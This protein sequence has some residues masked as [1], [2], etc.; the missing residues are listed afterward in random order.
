MKKSL[1]LSLFFAFIFSFTITAQTGSISGKI[2]TSD[3]K[4]AEFV[5]VGIKNTTHGSAA[6]AQGEFLL[7]NVQAGEHILVVSLSGFETKEINVKV[8]EGKNTQLPELMIKE[9]AKELQEVIITGVRNLNDRPVTIGKSG[10]KAMDL[11]QS[12]SSVDKEILDQ[13]QTQYMSDALKNF[14]GVYIMGNTGGVQQEIAARGFA[15]TSSNTFKNGVRYNNSVMPEM[16]AIERVEVLKGSAAILFGNVSAGGV[17]NLVTKKPTFTQGGELTM[18]FDSYNFYKPTVDVY[19]T[20]DKN[21]RAAFRINTTYEN[22]GSFRDEVKGERIYFNPS[23]IIK[24][25]KKTEILIEGD[26]LKDNRTSDF[27]V[28]AINYELIDI[29]RETFIGA[30]WS[31]YKTEQKS[32]SVSITHRFNQRWQ[33]KST[34]S[35]QFFNNDLFGTMRPNANNQFIK[36]NG[37][38]IRGVQ[39]TTIDEQYYIS[40]LDLTGK[41]STGGIGHTALI[42]A[43]IDSYSTINT[44]FNTINKYDSINV[45][46]TSLYKQRNDIPDLLKRTSTETPI[47]RTGAYIQ[48]LV[49]L[50][51]KI[52]LLAGVRFSYL[53]TGSSVFTYT[54]GAMVKTK[55][56]DFA[57][58]PR[59]GLVYQPT[60]KIS[61]FGSYANSFTPNTGVDVNGKQLSPSYIKQVEAGVKSNLFRDRISANITAYQIVNDNLAQ[62]SLLNGNTNTNIK[63]LAGEVTSKGLEIDVMSKSFFG[64][65]IIGGYS[66]NETRYTKSN[67]YVVG[68]LLRYNPAHTANASLYY[69]FSNGA[70]KGFNL[71][72]SGL[73]FGE[74]QAGRSTRVTVENDPYRLIRVP[75]YTTM[76]ASLGYTFNRMTVRVKASNIFDALSYNVHDD[77]SVNPIAPRQFAATLSYKF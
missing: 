26:Y 39:R 40:Q 53:E 10:I 67:T 41:F 7:D 31:Y 61:V 16:S 4:P 63:E 9:S 29:P 27:G 56:Y 30:R 54:P 33:L 64:F 62:T 24:A 74:R 44:A 69:T 35:A 18:R 1:Y 36:T 48:D 76:D 22:S 13:Q 15:F 59:L 14:N 57:T 77:N 32:A 2:Q 17:I 34:S 58:T 8:E 23:L 42:G 68:S 3:A 66:Y 55:Q 11:P 70:F 72:V 20:L 19:G 43:D 45:F 37:K 46:N 75:A 73:Y 50:G 5:T 47:V 12:I 21:N 28:G 51:K 25:G 60:K 65:M 49:D 52:K 38:W 6:N 71:G